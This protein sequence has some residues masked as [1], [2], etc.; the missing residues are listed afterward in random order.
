M[1]RKV[2]RFDAKAL[3]GSVEAPTGRVRT[4]RMLTMRSRALMLPKPIKSIPPRG[5]VAIRKRLNVSQNEFASL[6]NVPAV[7][8]I[9]WEKGRCKP[10]GAALRLLDLVRTKPG[11]LE[12]V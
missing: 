7:T 8:A 2:I 6:L 3:V 9:R 5:V 10:N 4:K 11:I 1:K 12:G